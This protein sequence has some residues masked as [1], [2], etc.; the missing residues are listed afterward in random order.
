MAFELLFDARRRVLL[1]RFG[2]RGT[3]QALVDM[4][5][6][7]QRFVARMGGCD[8]IIDFSA[9]EEIDVASPFLTNLAQQKPVLTGHRRVI[10]ASKEVV[11]G[12][13][14]MF[15][16]QQDAATGEAPTVVRTLREAY[17]VLGIA[18]PD[19]RPIDLT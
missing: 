9:V 12:L 13:S 4:Q 18:E 14:R 10:V 2:R 15:G 1:I 17:D 6:A 7:A 5:A 19:F 16:T 3:Q 8:G 11:Y